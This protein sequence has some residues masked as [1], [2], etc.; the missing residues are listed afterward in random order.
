M[1]PN[2]SETI[3]SKSHENCSKAML[4]MAAAGVQ[5]EGGMNRWLRNLGGGSERIL[6]DTVGYVS[7]CVCQDT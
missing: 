2:I 6:R 3:S 5:R 7:F 1:R 4:N